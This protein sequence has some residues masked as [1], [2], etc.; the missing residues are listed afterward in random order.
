VLALTVRT[1]YMPN[2]D[3]HTL[4]QRGRILREAAATLTG[5]A[6]GHNAMPVPDHTAVAKAIGAGAARLAPPANEIALPEPLASVVD[7][8]GEDGRDFVP[9]EELVATL[10]V[11]PTMF[12]R[13]MADLGCR[14]T[15]ERISAEDGTIRQVRGYRIADIT[16]AIRA[17]REDEQ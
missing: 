3:W 14:S 7:H 4:C 1:Y 12:G 9:S 2:E 6:A 8:L 10:A 5:H 17:F 13:Q 16:A 15:R 11:E